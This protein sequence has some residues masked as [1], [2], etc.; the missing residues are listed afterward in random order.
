MPPH[1]KLIFF[2]CGISECCEKCKRTDLWRLSRYTKQAIKNSQTCAKQRCKYRS[3]TLRSKDIYCA[4]PAA[5]IGSK[6]GRG[7]LSAN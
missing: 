4:V 1:N 5:H 7:N 2:V 6:E 3:T